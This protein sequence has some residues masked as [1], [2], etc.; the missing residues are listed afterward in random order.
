[1][2]E[3]ALLKAG[4]TTAEIDGSASV[5]FWEEDCEEFPGT[6]P[7]FEKKNHDQS[8]K[9]LIIYN[10]WNR[11][12]PLILIVVGSLLLS[13]VF[14]TPYCGVLFRCGCTWIWDGGI[15]GCNI[16]TKHVPHCPWCVAPKWA[17]WIPQWGTAVGMIIV[18]SIALFL[19]DEWMVSK[20]RKKTRLSGCYA[21]I[22]QWKFKGVVLGSIMVASFFVVGLIIAFVF[23]IAAGYP[24]FLWHY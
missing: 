21:A 17:I 10:V 1:M 13:W 6:P 12:A 16:Y 14:I 3:G 5:Q 22:S 24:H 2:D 9:D 23:K 11:F 7:V 4:A 19:L 20:F 15:E 8:W 18:A